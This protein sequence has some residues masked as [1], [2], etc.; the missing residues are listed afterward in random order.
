MQPDR[1]PSAA[2]MTDGDSD[3]VR[4]LCQA[5]MQASNGR[6]YRMR[7]LDLLRVNL[8]FDAALFHELSPRVPLSRAAVWGLDVDGLTANSAG[9][10]ETAVR[11]QPML[12]VALAGAGAATDS[13]AFPRG[14]RS[15][16]EWDKRV[17]K[18]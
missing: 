18:P 15:R 16:R 8:A 3:L 12:E 1:G 13:E 5:A 6:E 9:W 4:R 17:A 7:A 2:R 10:D 14:S 11:L